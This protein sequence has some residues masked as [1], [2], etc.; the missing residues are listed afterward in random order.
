MDAS[1]ENAPE[2][3]F[4]LASVPLSYPKPNQLTLWVVHVA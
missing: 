2:L 1:L 3:P 4:S